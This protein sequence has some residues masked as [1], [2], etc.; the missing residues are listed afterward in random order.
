MMPL[1]RGF[2]RPT[3]GHPFDPVTAAINDIHHEDPDRSVDALKHIQEMLSDTPHFFEDSVQTLTDA[4]LDELD[5]AFTPPEQ[6]R[7][8]EYFRLVKHLIQS[9][10]GIACNHSLIRRLT[11]DDLYALLHG[12]SLRLVQADRLGGTCAEL[13]KYINM[14]IIQS[15]STPDRLLVFKVMFKLLYNLVKD[16]GINKTDSEEEVAA[17]ADLI[18]KCLWKRCKVL[19]EDFK[20][21]RL[22]AGKLLRVIEEFLEGIGPQEWRRRDQEGIAL[23]GMPLR[24]IKTVLQ[25]MACK[26]QITSSLMFQV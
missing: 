4:L 11:F 21:G 13:S 24:T 15:L 17:H 10:S 7:Q 14:I 6:M 23:G 18:L 8:P 20:S 9:F 22:E 1:N 12:L 16:F 3:N 25:R 19:D 26:S 2:G 5:R